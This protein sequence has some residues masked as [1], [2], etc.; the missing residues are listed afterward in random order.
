MAV[1]LIRDAT[2]EAASGIGP[3][4]SIGDDNNS[5]NI[6]NGMTVSSIG[7]ATNVTASGIGPTISTGNDNDSSY[8]RPFH[9]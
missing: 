8:I 3:T 7:D 9:K 6:S 2:N 4:F 1:S 5:S